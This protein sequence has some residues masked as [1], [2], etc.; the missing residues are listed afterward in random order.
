MRK[1][2]NLYIV[3]RAMTIE[4]SWVPGVPSYHGD[5]QSD[6]Y[7]V[8][9]L[10]WYRYQVRTCVEQVVD[11]RMMGIVRCVSAVWIVGVQHH[12]WRI[13]PHKFTS[14]DWCLSCVT[15]ELWPLKSM[16]QC[17]KSSMFRWEWEEMHE[18]MV[19]FA[20]DMHIK[21]LILK[22][23]ANPS[24]QSITVKVQPFSYPGQQ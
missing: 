11:V 9:A 2:Q 18:G 15:T 8:C 20:H 7:Q 19:H 1:R 17:L 16:T 10:Q 21:S 3:T 13:D 12:R 24:L 5:G 6:V 4:P 14:Q 22:E 23:N